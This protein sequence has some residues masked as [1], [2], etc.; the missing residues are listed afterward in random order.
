VELKW[1]APQ[2][3]STEFY[4]LLWFQYHGGTNFGRTA[5]GPFIATSY[6]YDAPLDEYGVHKALLVSK[7]VFPYP[8]HC[9]P[10]IWFKFVWTCSCV[11]C[12]VEAPRE[13][14]Y[15]NEFHLNSKN[16]IL[17]Y[18]E[19]RSYFSFWS[20][21]WLL[22]PVFWRGVMMIGTLN[23]K[24]HPDNDFLSVLFWLF[25]ENGPRCHYPW[26]LKTVTTSQR[27]EFWICKCLIIVCGV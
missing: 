13:G 22:I 18:H 24:R 9:L 26:C 10:I 7:V 20:S 6:D 11:L 1:A 8:W 12:L 5:G 16:H 27:I 3:N 25:S 19:V 4:M 21:G 23:A 2:V 14:S 17:L 15:S